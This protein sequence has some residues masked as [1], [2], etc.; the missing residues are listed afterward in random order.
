[1]VRT[2]LTIISLFIGSWA[3]AL[4]GHA[5]K[6]AKSAPKLTAAIVKKLGYTDK[7]T[8]DNDAVWTLK[9]G[10]K[11]YSSYPYGQKIRGFVGP[12]PLF[13]AVD[14]QQKIV[15]LALAPN[16]ETPEYLPL[17][18]PLLKVWNGKTL[19]EAQTF[20]PDAITGATFTSKAII[21]NVKATAKAVSK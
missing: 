12:T 9:N 5:Q 6:T 1:M 16:A 7:F 21:E 13:L 17:M 15:G 18:K 2:S 19:K 14:Q 3:L 10:V 4:P 8:K 20:T 11:I